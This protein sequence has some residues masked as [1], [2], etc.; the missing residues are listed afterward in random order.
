MPKARQD[1]DNPHV[2]HVTEHWTETLLAISITISII[3]TLGVIL[4]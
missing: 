4:I 3:M 2:Y 1:K